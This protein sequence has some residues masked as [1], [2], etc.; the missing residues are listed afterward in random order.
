MSAHLISSRR[1]PGHC[2]PTHWRVR[3]RSLADI[4]DRF[5]QQWEELEQ[6]AGILNPFQSSHYVLAAARNLNEVAPPL[7]LT[8][9]S[10]HDL[11][12]VMVFE[13]VCGTRRLPVRHLRAWQTPHTYL[14]APVLRTGS[15]ERAMEVFWNFLLKGVHEWHGVE[16]PRFPNHDPVSRVF[17]GTSQA[18][19]IPCL[20]GTCWERASLNLLE[21]RGDQAVQQLSIKRARSLRRGWRELAK[22]GNVQ[23]QIQRDSDQ[24]ARCAEELMQL[25]SLGW[26]S[27]TGTALASQAAHQRFFREMIAGFNR[28]QSVFFTQITVNGTAI[29]SV[30]H[31]LANE[32]AYAFKLGWDPRTERGCPGFQIKLRMAA[33]GYEQLPG[34]NRIDSCSSPGSFI[35]HVWPHRR[36]FCNRTY[37]TSPVGNLT[38]TMVNGLRWVRNKSR[39]VSRTWFHSDFDRRNDS[40]KEH[41]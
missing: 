21:C 18:E 27:E 19:K 30:A 1:P 36:A 25:E 38:A 7:I 35:E 29:I 39:E 26:K 17:D 31:L 24:M 4:D 10:P 34:V 6:D 9:E 5:R 32:T 2:S 40:Q 3:C 37:V 28:Q 20:K 8:V 23:F 15:A 14:D 22:R 33:E 11:Q 16:F 12:A 13:T 41:A